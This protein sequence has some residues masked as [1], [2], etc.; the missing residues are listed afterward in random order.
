MPVIE[1]ISFGIESPV[2]ATSSQKT[3]LFPVS[4]KEGFV[5]SEPGL[6]ADFLPKYAFCL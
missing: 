2:A 6:I 1:E 5:E 3:P 4:T